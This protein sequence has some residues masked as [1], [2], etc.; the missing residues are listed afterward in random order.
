[1]AANRRRHRRPQPD[2]RPFECLP[3][4]TGFNTQQVSDILERMTLG[5]ERS[6]TIDQFGRHE[7]LWAD[8]HTSFLQLPHDRMTMTFKLSD[9]ISHSRT[10]LVQRH[11]LIQISG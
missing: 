10:R 4:S 3:D 5:V 9:Q 7:L 1:M 2:T 11:E 8:L 6:G